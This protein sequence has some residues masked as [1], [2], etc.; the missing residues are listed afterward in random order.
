MKRTVS[1]ATGCGFSPLPSDFPCP[2]KSVWQD[3]HPH[4]SGRWA[5]RFCGTPGHMLPSHG[6]NMGIITE[7]ENS[8]VVP[9]NTA[10]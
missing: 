8:A 2:M 1:R 7:E 10:F 9:N 3:T 6:H 5:C 4:S